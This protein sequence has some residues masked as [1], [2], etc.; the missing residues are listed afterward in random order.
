MRITK[1]LLIEGRQCC[2]AHAQWW[3]RLGSRLRKSCLTYI[4]SDQCITC[5]F[6]DGATGRYV[7]CFVT[8][9]IHMPIL[10]KILS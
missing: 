10:E 7:V 1:L 8:R 9:V 2:G 4:T 5:V 6:Q 3:L